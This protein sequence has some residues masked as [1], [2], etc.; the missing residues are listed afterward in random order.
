MKQKRILITGANG[1]VG[2]SLISYLKDSNF[3]LIA[4]LRKGSV[5][6]FPGNVEVRLWDSESGESLEKS[7]DDTDIVI[8]TAGLKG[9]EQCSKNMGRLIESNV[10]FTHRL[11]NSAANKNIKIIFT[12]SYWVYGHTSALPYQE[13]TVLSPCEPYGWSKAIAER[14]IVSSGFDYVIL[15]LAN[16]FGYGS[17]K[18]YEETA[19][20]FLKKSMAAK[21][22]ELNNGGVNSIDLIS[23]DDVCRIILKILASMNK[24]MILNV[25]SGTAVSIRKLA[26]SVNFISREFTGNTAQIKNSDDKGADRIAFSDRWVDISNLKELTGF[27]AEPLEFSLRKLASSLVL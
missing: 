15:R 8:H 5:C 9:Y 26:E 2:S 4:F 3:K 7:I 17:G 13:N 27:V 6:D 10:I 24:N 1:Y 23:I 18:D 22:I 21:E 25:G 11:L 12:S 20:F 16:V 19:S 14:M